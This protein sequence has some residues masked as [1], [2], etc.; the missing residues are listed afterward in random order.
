MNVLGTAVGKAF[1]ASIPTQDP[2]QLIV[3]H[4]S[5][6]LEPGALKTKFGGSPDGHRGVRSVS[7][8]VHS[9][10]YFRVLAGVGRAGAAREYVL[11]PLSAWERGHFGEN[12]AGTEE[13]WRRVG[14]IEGRMEKEREGVRKRLAEEKE[15]KKTRR[16][17]VQQTPPKAKVVQ[18]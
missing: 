8:F 2:T 9:Q 7:A 15:K 13:V 6:N 1:R 17:L 18:E 5:L 14:E 11:G 16:A 4:D 10:D 12:G 3:L